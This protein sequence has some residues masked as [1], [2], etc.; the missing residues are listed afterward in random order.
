M[1][2]SRLNS[3]GPSASSTSCTRTPC[4]GRAR[5][6]IAKETFL[7]DG[8]VQQILARLERDG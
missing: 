8:T 6:A 2:T 5:Y 4:S 1:Q 7:S 3:T